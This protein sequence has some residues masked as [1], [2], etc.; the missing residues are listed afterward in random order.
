MDRLGQSNSRSG[1][2]PPRGTGGVSTHIL[3]CLFGVWGL[4]GCITTT[5]LVSHAHIGHAMTTWHDTPDKRGLLATAETRAQDGWRAANSGC[6]SQDP[7]V[8]GQLL[9]QTLVALSP[10]LAD[11]E[12]AVSYGAVRALLGAIEHIEFAAA[13][14]DASINMV[15]SVVELSDDGAALAERLL[16]TAMSLRAQLADGRV[17]CR[18]LIAALDRDING[19]SPAAEAPARGLLQFR[20]QLEAVLSRETNPPYEPVS[21]RYVLGLVRLPNGKWDFRLGRPPERQKDPGYAFGGGYR[22]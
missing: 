1:V 22:Y 7:A 16:K 9:E 19:A 4:S 10:G 6:R 18:A 8:A 20:T 21:R 3:L 13:A 11:P 17:R 14:D 2:T 5:P 12:R 15:T